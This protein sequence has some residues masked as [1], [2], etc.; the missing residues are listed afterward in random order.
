[1]A[2]TP[3]EIAFCTIMGA[4]AVYLA[5]KL[6]HHLSPLQAWISIIYQPIPCIT[7]EEY[8]QIRDS[9]PEELR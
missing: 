1:M 8:K 5:F 7:Y 6:M 2:A 4:W 3:T 9:L